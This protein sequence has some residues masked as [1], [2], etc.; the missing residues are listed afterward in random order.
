MKKIVIC[1]LVLFFALFFL[2]H[3][4]GHQAVKLKTVRVKQG[5][6][7]STVIASGEIVPKHAIS[8]KSQ[9]SGIIEKIDVKEGDEVK[10]GQ[11]LMSINPNPTPQD[12]AQLLSQFKQ[13]KAKYHDS[14]SKYHR[15][16]AISDHKNHFISEQTLE[17][18]KQLMLANKAAFL[19]AKQVLELQKQGKTTIA[20]KQ[21]R[22]TVQSPIAGRVLK[23]NMDVGD[24]VVPVTPYQAGTPLIT[25]ANMNQ[26]IFKGEVSQ[27]D[28]GKLKAGMPAKL[29]IAPFPDM[30]LKAKVSQIALESLTNTQSQQSLTQSQPLFQ[31]PTQLQNGFA[32]ELAGFTLPK[33]K[34]IRAGYQATADITV[35]TANNT[36]VL[37][38]RVL[39][40]SGNNVY[41][42]IPIVKNKTK[43]Q[44]IKIGISSG[45]T[46]QV[47]SGLKLGDEVVE[48]TVKP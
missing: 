6:L 3:Y 1:L 22:S 21:I 12:Y 31:T 9:L 23:I 26:L 30:P 29:T 2:Y 20:G 39:H 10:K 42:L 38:E 46:V 15:D 27:T 47:L 8:V 37:P 4:I 24:S 43:K 36:L 5:T 41:V 11:A 44:T 48:P 7:S 34:I 35:K 28:I 33:D 40:F 13:T 45:T 19:Y 16:L 14:L 17:D 25:M 32:I 18:D